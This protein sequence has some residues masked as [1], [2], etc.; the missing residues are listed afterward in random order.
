MATQEQVRNG[1][2]AAAGV[3]VVGGGLL[4]LFGWISVLPALVLG[5]L[6]GTA[7]LL[8]SQRHRDPAVQGAG[9][10]AALLGIIVAVVVAAMVGTGG[11]IAD[12]LGLLVAVSYW[13]VVWPALAAM[14]GAILRLQL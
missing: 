3:G 4:G 8:A 13:E 11:R 2:L 9:A 10:G 6:T 14:A 12:A 7:A 5:L 1:A